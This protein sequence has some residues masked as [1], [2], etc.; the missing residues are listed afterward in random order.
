M[1]LKKSKFVEM[2]EP[3]PQIKQLKEQAETLHK[4]ETPSAILPRSPLLRLP[5]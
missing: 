4:C 3:S 1:S 5:R 2:I